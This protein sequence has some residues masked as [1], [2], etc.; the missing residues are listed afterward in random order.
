MEPTDITTYEALVLQS[1]AGRILKTIM[2]PILRNYDLT[3]MQWSVIG[4]IHTAGKKG[5]RI[6]DL[7]DQIDTS[8]AFITNSVNALE[9]KDLVYRVG[10][11]SDNRAKM[12]CI[13]PEFRRK[14]SK[15]EK[16][17]RERLSETLGAQI[18]LEH[19]SIYLEVLRQ[20]AEL[21]LRMQ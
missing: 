2:Q 3:M 8:L 11:E 4:H 17:L 21:D 15:I 9:A 16:E 19:I 1:R 7:A 20:I 5:I 13:N 14:I 18:K 10:H 6:S 12:V